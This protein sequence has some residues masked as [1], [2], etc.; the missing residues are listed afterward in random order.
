MAHAGFSTEANP[1]ALRPKRAQRLSHDI[2]QSLAIIMTLGSLVDSE[3]L[4][5]PAVIGRLDHMRRELDWIRAA[6]H[7]AH[8]GGTETIDVGEVAAEVWAATAEC[9]TCAFRLTRQTNT[10]ANVD[11]GE[12]RRSV[13]NLVFN[14]VR[15]AGPDGQVELR[16]Y[17]DGGDVVIEVADDGPG[18]G[19]IQPQQG[20]GL[21]TVRRFAASTTGRMTIQ[22]SSLGGALVRLHLPR[23]LNTQRLAGNVI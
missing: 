6:L 21:I 1:A 16:V 11:P 13:R 23:T 9:V 20:L 3:P 4:R 10:F 12:L 8:V 15:A 7:E 18:F 5:R 19:G 22:D 2:R 14:A 17:P